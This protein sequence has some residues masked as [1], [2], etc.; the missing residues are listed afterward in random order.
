MATREVF[1]FGNY[2]TTFAKLKAFFPD[3]PELEAI[4][5][6]Q[7]IDFPAGTWRRDEYHSEAD[8]AARRGQIVCCGWRWSG[9][10]RCT[11][12]SC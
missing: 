1:I 3:D 7:L 6:D 8:G 11:R 4:T 12:S 2:L 9:S 5:R 10:R